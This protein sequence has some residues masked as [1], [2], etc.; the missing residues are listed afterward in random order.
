MLAIA[1]FI[2]CQ[3]LLIPIETR[4]MALGGLAALLRTMER[5]QERLNPELSLAGIVPCCV[6]LR[7]NLSREI[8]R[9]LRERFADLVFDSTVRENVRLAEAPS[10]E[11]PITSYAP[12]STGAA[13]YRAIAVEWLEREQKRAVDE[14]TTT[15]IG[16]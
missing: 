15:S 14:Q 5:V 11:Q 7:T 6:D 13:D 8:V 10:F 2:A 9:R 16:H 3:S 12:D 1:A 4:V